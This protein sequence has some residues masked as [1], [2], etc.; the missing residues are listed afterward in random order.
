MKVKYLEVIVIYSSR[1]IRNNCYLGKW[2]K[3]MPASY[4]YLKETV[5]S[6]DIQDVWSEKKKKRWFGNRRIS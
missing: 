6:L 3:Q 4:N 5:S 2:N 1:Y